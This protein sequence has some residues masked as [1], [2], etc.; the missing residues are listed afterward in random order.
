[1]SVPTK[2]DH[3]VMLEAMGAI[4]QRAS[5]DVQAEQAT[6][7]AMIG[8]ALSALYQAATCH[9]KCSSGPHILEALSGRTYNLGASAYLLIIRGY[10][11]EALN[12]VRSI[13]EISNLIALSA[14]DKDGLREWLESGY[15]R[16]WL[17]WQLLLAL[18]L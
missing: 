6:E 14:V 18:F 2:L 13:G 16:P 4:T 9:R 15:V 8:T 1:M 7:I 11:D 5:T 10:Y 17:N 3:L 12:L